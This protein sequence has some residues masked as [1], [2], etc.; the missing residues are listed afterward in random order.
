[1]LIDRLCN[2]LFE[3]YN[4]FFLKGNINP[5]MTPGYGRAY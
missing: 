4:T 5:F 3:V 1:V 2:F